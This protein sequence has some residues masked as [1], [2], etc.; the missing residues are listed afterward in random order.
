VIT[1]LE[2]G[3]YCSIQDLGRRGYGRWG[4]SP[5]GAADRRS[6]SLANRLVGNFEGAA[7]LELTFGPVR[8]HFDE[9]AIIA[10]TGAAEVL[11][12]IG[13]GAPNGPF[14]VGPGE[15]R[16]HAPVRGVR[17]YVAV[18][19]GIDTPLILGSRSTDPSSGFGAVLHAGDIVPV[20]H[21]AI[22]SDIIVG[23]APTR[24]W[25]QPALLNADLGPQA[26]WFTKE[27]L[28]LLRTQT[29]MVGT[30]SN[31]VGVRLHGK[32]L[33]RSNLEEMMSEPVIRGAIEV[34]TDG[35]PIV[36]MADH[37]TTCGYPVIAV[38]DSRS[39]DSAAQL[40]P[41]DVVQIQLRSMRATRGPS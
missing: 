21:Y 19:G 22:V 14:R 26:D 40:R 8:L 36:F 37:P 16:V 29:Y 9:S 28:A 15:V 32:S 3:P 25:P 5:G 23:H 10:V 18:R 20:G 13:G 11:T 35:Q 30:D 2:P 12:V 1:I 34:T 41:G 7:T 24:G 4:I 31:R 33:V 17:S 27:A 6:H 38:L 39:A